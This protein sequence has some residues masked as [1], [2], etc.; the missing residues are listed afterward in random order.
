[1]LLGELTHDRENRRARLRELAARR[2]DPHRLTARSVSW[3]RSS[4]AVIGG[5]GFGGL[6]GILRQFV[7]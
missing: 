7:T 4:I 3:R 2:L 6:F 5:L 1:M